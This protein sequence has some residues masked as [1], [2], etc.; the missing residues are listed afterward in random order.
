MSEIYSSSDA[1][2]LSTLSSEE[3]DHINHVLADLGLSGDGE[4]TAHAAATGNDASQAP[5]SESAHLFQASSGPDTPFDTQSVAAASGAA[6]TGAETV[7]SGTGTSLH[8]L[9]AGNGNDTLFGG[10]GMDTLWGGEAPHA[11]GSAAGASAGG[12]AETISA[13]AGLDTTYATLGTIATATH[14]AYGDVAVT[15]TATDTIDGSASAQNARVEAKAIHSTIFGGAGN[16]TIALYD[17]SGAPASMTGDGMDSIHGSMGDHATL[18]SGTG[19]EIHHVYGMGDSIMG[20]DGSDFFSLARHGIGQ[21]TL[22]G[23]TGDDNLAF[24]DR[25][26]ADAHFAQNAQ[27]TTVSFD[28]GYSATL[29]NVE[30]LHFKDTVYNI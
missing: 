29:R 15:H 13:A 7:A 1:A 11:G 24:E 4:G 16:D 20:G 12:G 26:F 2:S 21:D 25:S 23:G 27:T 19:G 9:Y 3:A 10:N 14:A 18:S 30:H 22:D 6:S 8:L 28:D 17:L 5:P